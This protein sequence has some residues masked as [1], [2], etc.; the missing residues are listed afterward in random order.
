MRHVA[1]LSIACLLLA[2]CGVGEVA[3]TAA[4]GGASAA[5]QAQ[6]GLKTEQRVKDELAAAAAVDAARRAD[7]EKAA[8]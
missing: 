5:Q 8:Q 4:A 6:E 2:G 7:A 1:G 3:V